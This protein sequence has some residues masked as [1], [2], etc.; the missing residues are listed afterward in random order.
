MQP[1]SAGS[2]QDPYS[3]DPYSQQ[4][5]YGDP[6]AAQPPYG[7]PPYGQQYGDPLQSYGQP[8]YG[9]QPPQQYS[10][11]LQA[12]QY[13]PQQGQQQY[14]DPYGP[15]QD[16]YGQAQYP[17]SASPYP[18]TGGPAS[19]G[20]YPGQPYPPPPPP[21][22]GYGGYTVPGYQSTQNNT[23]ALLGMIFGILSIA[24]SICCALPGIGFGV[25]GL[26]L[27]I[28]GTKKV[29]DGVERGKGMAL[30]GIIC[31][32]IGLV[33]AA[34]VLAYGFSGGYESW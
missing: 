31:G 26:V 20:A 12:P 25:A 7:Q 18:T 10:D 30:T 21:P 6:Y 34:F 24:L 11:P 32:S 4:P 27:G 22:I 15:A 16:P 28:V 9:Q 13:D 17:A 23:P 14:I 8:S 3:Q 5:Q 1:G 33:I 2:G 19:G 29:S